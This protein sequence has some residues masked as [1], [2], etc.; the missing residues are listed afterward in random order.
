MRSSGFVTQIY[1]F[2]I[3]IFIKRKWKLSEIPELSIAAVR[4]RQIF[5]MLILLLYFHPFPR[6]SI[7]TF[8][9]M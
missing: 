6:Q 1:Q 4:G 7:S 5:L 9:T 8:F 3:E 2:K